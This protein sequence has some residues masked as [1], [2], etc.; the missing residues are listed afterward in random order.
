[1]AT[2]AEFPLVMKHPAYRPARKIAEATPA[3]PPQPGQ[4]LIPGKPEQ[5]EAEWMPQ[6]TVMNEDQ[7]EYYASKGYVAPGIPDAA[8]FSTAQ[9]APYNGQTPSEWPK[10]IDGKLV[11]DPNT[12]KTADPERRTGFLE[13]PKI[14][15][16][17]KY[18]P[19]RKIA[20]EVYEEM[21][22]P[23]QPFV[24]AQP[25]QWEPEKYPPVTAKDAKDE[26]R[27]RA[28][29][30]RAAGNSNPKAFSPAAVT[31]VGPVSEWPK[32][33]NGQL[34]QDPKI[35]VGPIQYPKWCKPPT[36]EP[37]LAK[38]AQ[39]EAQLRA[40]WGDRTNDDAMIAQPKRRGRPPKQRE[41][42]A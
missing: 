3:I 37:V 7:R 38:N 41:A 22:N 27:W 18:E 39:H 19:A 35:P 29:G 12:P 11:Q 31:P 17:P 10:M 21:P 5:W 42:Q 25:A 15:T 16:H 13:Y 14:L 34:M 30:Y 24:P 4:A 26:E 9:A 33:V 36:G 20:D 32:M 23:G 6:V 8:A 40:S 2:Y 28:K 1:M